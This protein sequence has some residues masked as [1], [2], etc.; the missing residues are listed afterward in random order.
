MN[1]TRKV[2]LIGAEPATVSLYSRHLEPAGFSLASATLADPIPEKVRDCQAEAVLLDLSS[3][4]P[5]GAEALRRIT[6]EPDFVSLPLFVL[7]N[8]AG[9]PPPTDELAP[10]AKRRLKLF[11]QGNTSAAEVT[12]A[13][14]QILKDKDKKA[15]SLPVSVPAAQNASDG[16]IP[17]DD[18]LIRD[19]LP[20]TKRLFEVVR[21]F[22]RSPERQRRID[23]LGV[24]RQEALRLRNSFSAGNSEVLANFTSALERLFTALSKDVEAVNA[25]TLRTVS[26]AMDFLTQAASATSGREE[27]EAT[28]MRMLAVDDDAVCLRMLRLALSTNGV[29]VVACDGPEPALH[30]LKTGDFDVIFSDI[31]MPG[32]NGFEFVEELRKLPQHRATPVVFVTALSDFE[33][34]SRSVLS[35]GCDLIAKPFTACEVLVK[36]LTLA[37][38]R[39]FDS[40]AAAAP[41]ERLSQAVRPNGASEDSELPSPNNGGNGQE[42]SARDSSTHNGLA[43]CGVLSVEENGRIRSINKAAAELLG[44]SPGE[45]TPGQLRAL[46]PD[47]L[48]SEETK[49]LLSQALA[50]TVKRMSGI[51][52]TA[53]REDNSTIRLLVGVGETWV[54]GQRSIMCLLQPACPPVAA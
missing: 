29:S 30:H 3:S 51:E 25:S 8:G 46:I 35:G 27:I 45:A 10:D 37:L 54:N 23:L 20:A 49:T 42:I 1:P 50:G 4:K 14:E 16:A 44:Y 32:M 9:E 6:S 41:V 13:I 22:C 40:A 52:M 18:E 31:M 2:L 38:K 48:Q 33:T 28:P 5:G 47:E 34:R 21:T 17:A 7:S 15:T 53:R 36:G 26:H 24:M 11:P 43:G 39:R 12:R 19:G